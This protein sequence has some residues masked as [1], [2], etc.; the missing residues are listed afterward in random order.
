M[1]MPLN[2]ADTQQASPITNISKHLDQDE[3]ASVTL[4]G[5]NLLSA[6]T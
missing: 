2:P 4:S 6:A 5:I 1:T 3:T